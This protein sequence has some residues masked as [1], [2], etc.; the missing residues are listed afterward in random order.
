S[1]YTD[2]SVDMNLTFDSENSGHMGVHEIDYIGERKYTNG[3]YTDMFRT[4]YFEIRWEP[5]RLDKSEISR[6]QD[7]CYVDI[8]AT[9]NKYL[10]PDLY[11][12]VYSGDD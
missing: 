6:N 4:D 1:Q 2:V 11:S 7:N 5:K 10:C 3:S 9:I 12:V 8:Q